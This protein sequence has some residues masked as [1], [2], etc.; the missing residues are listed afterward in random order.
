MK[1]IEIIELKRAIDTLSTSKTPI[2]YELGK[3]KVRIERIME[4]I[5]EDYNKARK[6][7]IEQLS[8]KDE[9]GKSVIVDN[10]YVFG[11][12]EE[13]ARKLL[14]DLEED[15]MKKEVEI[16]LHKISE[17]KFKM[18]QSGNYEANLMIPIVE[19]LT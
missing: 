8:E 14:T 16:E 3:N 1:I 6:L 12:N 18:L 7:I 19:F 5:I 15:L 2:W 13:E 11:N 9:N 10:K 17:D 4:P